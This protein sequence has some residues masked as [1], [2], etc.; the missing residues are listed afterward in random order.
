[1]PERL[2]CELTIKALYKS[3]YLF[4]WSKLGYWT[5]LKHRQSRRTTAWRRVTVIKYFNDQ[6]VRTLVKWQT[7]ERQTCNYCAHTI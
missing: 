5:I 6:L 4:T 1:M 2:E 7:V 3:T